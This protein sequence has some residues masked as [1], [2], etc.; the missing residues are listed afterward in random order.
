MKKQ[1]DASSYTTTRDTTLAS[2]LV[3]RD[4]LELVVSLDAQQRRALVFMG[5]VDDRPRRGH[6]LAP[7]G[8]GA[9]IRLQ[10]APK[11]F[12]Q[13][14]RDRTQ[15]H[16][17]DLIQERQKLF[18]GFGGG[19]VEI[20]RIGKAQTVLF[21]DQVLAD[22]KLRFVVYPVPRASFSS[23]SRALAVW[24][25]DRSAIVFDPALDPEDGATLVDFERHA[26]PSSKMVSICAGVISIVRPNRKNAPVSLAFSRNVRSEISIP[27]AAMISTH[28]AGVLPM[29]RI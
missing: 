14:A 9:G 1:V 16:I 15:R 2:A 27:C 18:R 28:C 4:A 10:L 8:I 17:P 24:T 25:G 26:C 22:L 23:R 13:R 5:I 3:L 29:V 20:D 11:A 7:P 21:P 6:D 12:Q 19:V